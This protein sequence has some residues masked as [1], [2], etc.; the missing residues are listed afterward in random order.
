[1]Y[2]QI[3]PYYVYVGSL[4]VGSI[5]SYLFNR[6]VTCCKKENAQAK[7]SLQHLTESSSSLNDYELEDEYTGGIPQDVV[8]GILEDSVPRLNEGYESTVN[9]IQ[10]TIAHDINNS[11]TAIFLLNLLKKELIKIESTINSL[12]SS[13]INDDRMREVRYNIINVLLKELIQLNKIND[14]QTLSWLVNYLAT[15]FDNTGD[16]E[17]HAIFRLLNSIAKYPL[18]EEAS[19]LALTILSKYDEI[20]PEARS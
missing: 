5:G 17:K 4:I 13:S 8:R 1:M 9:Y 18:D 16:S 14:S 11:K 2:N 20:F 19:L 12:H 10:E 7:E 3:N 15:I 6:I